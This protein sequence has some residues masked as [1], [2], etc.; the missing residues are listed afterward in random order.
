[1]AFEKISFNERW[2]FN[3][4]PELYGFFVGKKEDVGENH[5]NVYQ[6]ELDNGEITEFWGATALDSQMNNVKLGARIKIVFEGM[7]D[8]PKRKGKQFKAFSVYVDK[9]IIKDGY[10]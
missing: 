2:D 3:E 4:N 7:K 1:M 8:S 10:N 9:D 5:S 6:V